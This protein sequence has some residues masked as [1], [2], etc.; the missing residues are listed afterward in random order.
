MLSSHIL[1]QVQS[2]C[3]RVGI[4]ASGRLVAQGRVEEL[5]AIAGTDAITYEVGTV[6]NPDGVEAVLRAI[7]GVIAVDR[8]PG[9]RARWVV[10]AQR[11]V[12]ADAIAALTAA[13]HPVDH[14][15]RRGEDLLEIY[16]QLA[17]EGRDDRPN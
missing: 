8:E 17:P 14:L 16:R 13:G 3:D 5:A 9:D 7:D 10:S 15:R 11:D 12:A 6:G 2:I 4:F 1:G